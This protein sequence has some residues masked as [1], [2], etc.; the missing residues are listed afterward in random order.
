MNFNVK[1]KNLA[2]QEKGLPQTISQLIQKYKLDALWDNIQKL[3]N[4][5]LQHADF[6]RAGEISADRIKGGTLKLGGENNISGKLEIVDEQGNGVLNAG[7][8]GLELQNGTKIIGANGILSQFQF[9]EYDWKEVG[10]YN[11]TYPLQ[12]NTYKFINV[13]IYIPS[14]FEVT[15]ARVILKHAPIK[16]GDNIGNKSVWGYCRNVK[17]YKQSEQDSFYKEYPI[18]PSEDYSDE[19]VLTTEIIGAFG[20]DG[21]TAQSANQSTHQSEVITSTDI[22]NSLQSGFTLLQVRTGNDIPT[23]NLDVNYVDGGLTNGY[24]TSVYQQTGAMKVLVNIV[25][26]IK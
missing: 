12:R 5:V 7:K 26:F 1:P 15:E 9:G 3:V 19:E 24:Q 16:W 4:E 17:L 11:E 8:D 20:S 22:K 21:F 10:Y 23:Y 18:F 14:N 25:G 6:I 2:R 13:P